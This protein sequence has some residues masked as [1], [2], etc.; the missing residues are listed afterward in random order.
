MPSLLDATPEE[1]AQLRAIAQLRAAGYSDA[2]IFGGQ[3]NLQAG[4]YGLLPYALDAAGI[5]SNYNVA[6]GGLA[7]GQQR[8]YYDQVRNPYNVVS[9]TQYMRDTGASSFL[10]DPVLG[11]V[12]ASPAARYGDFINGLLFTPGESGAT[13]AQPQAAGAPNA[14]GQSWIDAWRAYHPGQ[15]DPVPGYATNA[16]NTGAQQAAA[17]N[18]SGTLPGMTSPQFGQTLSAGGVPGMSSLNEAEVGRLSPDQ[19]AQWM[20]LVQSTGLTSDANA[21]YEAFAD[22]YRTRGAQ[23]AGTA[24]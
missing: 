3:A 24:R 23:S 22:R 16:M 4:G 20:G 12:Q 8:L 14:T 18:L 7:E 21:A 15:P 11:Q 13:G 1:M 10:T 19:R 6:R 17:R 5:A 9:A 2:D